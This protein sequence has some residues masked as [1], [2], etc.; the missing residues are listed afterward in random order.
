MAFQVINHEVLTISRW[1]AT[2]DRS[3]D[4]F[5]GGVTVDNHLVR[6]GRSVFPAG[7]LTQRWSA[8][9]DPEVA[10]QGFGVSGSI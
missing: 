10:I 1:L 4:W 7:R 2:I 6:W 8:L 3:L 9:P 5:A